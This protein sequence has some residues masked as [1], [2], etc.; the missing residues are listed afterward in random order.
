MAF[1]FYV[2]VNDTKKS[3]SGESDRAAYKGKIPGSF[4]SCGVVSPRDA[5]TGQATGKRR[6]EPIVMRKKV[7]LMSPL[8]IKALT[9]NEVLP[10][11]VF[12]FVHTSTDGK[13][14]IFYKITLSNATVSSHKMVLPE[15]TGDST[16]IELTEEICFTFQKIE[17]NHVKGRKVTTDDWTSQDN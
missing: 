6:H 14:E 11:V 8:F 9:S 1:E 17:W 10:T 15:T 3:F 16:H 12:E 2:T 7:G 13:E 4:F 5:T